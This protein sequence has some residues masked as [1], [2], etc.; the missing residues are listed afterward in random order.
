MVG[1]KMGMDSKAKLSMVVINDGAS[2]SNENNEDKEQ[3]E[4]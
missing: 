3:Y 2:K 4:R 1:H